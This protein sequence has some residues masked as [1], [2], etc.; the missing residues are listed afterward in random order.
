M[1]EGPEPIV[2]TDAGEIRDALEHTE[3]LPHASGDMREG[4]TS[5]LRASM[6]RF[7]GPLEH[8]DR[9]RAVVDAIDAI[10]TEQAR[11]FAAEL[12]ASRL[13]GAPLD[14]IEIAGAVPT[15]V[16]ASCLG[17]GAPLEQ[18]VA[19]MLAIVSVIGRGAPSS[20]ESDDATE[21]MLGLG[22]DQSGGGVPTVSIL[23]Q[24]FDA[25]W[26][27]LTTTLAAAA[28]GMPAVA[29]VPRTRR[30]A[31]VDVELLR[32]RVAEGSE[33]V[34]EIGQAGLPFGA[35][36]HQ[37]PGQALAEAIVAGIVAAID[38]SPYRVDPSGIVTDVDGRPTALPMSVSS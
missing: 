33:L 27:L 1:T 7:S 35:G 17:L 38:A 19:D 6:A 20:R 30:V 31:G 25:T 2:L 13:T 15:E 10:D 28:T 11:R 4:A 29:A 26:S 8:A 37:C 9:R 36:P 24:N 22:S 3:L 34:L 12:T 23:Y 14:G 21:R 5:R 18:V 32:G 16:L